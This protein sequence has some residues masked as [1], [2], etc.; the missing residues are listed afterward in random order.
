MLQLQGDRSKVFAAMLATTHIYAL[1]G[2]SA[3]LK[4]VI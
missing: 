2:Y 1:R 3:G 4:A